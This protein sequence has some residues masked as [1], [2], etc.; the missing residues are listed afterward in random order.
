VRCHIKY[1]H[2]ERLMSFTIHSA[3][4]RRVH[5]AV[6]RKYREELWRAANVAGI[7]CQLKHQIGVSILFIDP[8]SPD[9]DNLITALWQAL[10]GKCG[11]PPTILSDDRQIVFI[12]DVGLMLP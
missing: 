12:K 7:H 5:R 2:H 1:N 8:T 11:K 9:F 3:P 4:H 6:L 10:D